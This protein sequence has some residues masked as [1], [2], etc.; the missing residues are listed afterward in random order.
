[1]DIK[2]RT[3]LLVVRTGE[4]HSRQTYRSDFSY[5]FVFLVTE[6]QRYAIRDI[7]I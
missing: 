2:S 1:M 3:H 4:L 6:G 5:S 7:G